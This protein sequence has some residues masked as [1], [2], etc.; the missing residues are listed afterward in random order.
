MVKQQKERNP[1]VE[2]AVAILKAGGMILYPTDTVWGVGCDATNPDA[3]AKVYELK[4]SEN[5]KA[6]IVLCNTLDM[7]ARHIS[8]PPMIAFEVMEVSTKPLT[9]I[10]PGGVGVASN[11][12][13]EE[14][15]LAIRIPDHEFCQE[16]IRRFGR[17]IVSTS[18]NITGEETPRRLAE[19][20]KEI[21][22]GV[23]YIIPPRFEGAATRK[24]SSIIKFELDGAFEIIRE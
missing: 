20:S 4:R 18:A 3:V 15:T 22:E 19:V 11:L 12:I 1:V 13:P 16:L 2:E 23:D 14:G 9:A 8:R 5:K 21:V 17:P 6:M 7:A 10:M 24:P